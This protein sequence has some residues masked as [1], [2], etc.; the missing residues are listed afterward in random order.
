MGYISVLDESKNFVYIYSLIY[1][2]STSFMLQSLM[3]TNYMST[4][5]S[6]SWIIVSTFSVFQIFIIWSDIDIEWLVL[7]LGV[8]CL[9]AFYLSQ[10]IRTTI[11]SDVYDSITEDPVS[12]AVRLCYLISR[13]YHFRLE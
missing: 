11:R 12:G 2:A 8:V 10:G 7:W 3:S 5:S 4:L 13:P 6:L 9:F 1:G